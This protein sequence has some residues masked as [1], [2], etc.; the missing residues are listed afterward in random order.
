M[1]AAEFVRFLITST[2]DESMVQY[3]SQAQLDAVEQ[4][5]SVLTSPSI[6]LDHIQYLKSALHSVFVTNIYYTE[7]AFKPDLD[8]PIVRFLCY[9]SIK[10]EVSFIRVDEITQRP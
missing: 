2:Q 6:L 8:F 9:R 5:R 7:K 3:Y 10:A 1:T 4:L